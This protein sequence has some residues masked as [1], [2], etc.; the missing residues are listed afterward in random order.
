ME[1]LKSRVAATS[2][3]GSGPASSP[4]GAQSRPQ[5]PQAGAG[6][7]PA[8][9]SG[10]AP[11][12]AAAAAR[13]APASA[14]AAAPPVQHT[15][16][17]QGIPLHLGEPGSALQ[18]MAVLTHASPRQMEEYAAGGGAAATPGTPAGLLASDARFLVSL[19]RMADTPRSR[20]AA[21]MQMSAGAMPAPALL[22]WAAQEVVGQAQALL[23][24]RLVAG[25]DAAASLPAEPWYAAALQLSQAA[26]ASR[27]QPP[28]PAPTTELELLKAFALAADST[29]SYVS[30]EQLWQLPQL[31]ELLAAAAGRSAKLA[32]TLDVAGFAMAATSEA[33]G[34]QQWLLPQLR[35][36]AAQARAKAVAALAPQ[37]AATGDAPLNADDALAAA[38][39]GGAADASEWLAATSLLRRAEAELGC[40]PSTWSSGVAGAS[41]GALA[42]PV[43]HLL[44]LPLQPP[45]LAGMKDLQVTAEEVVGWIKAAAASPGTMPAALQSRLAAARQQLAAAGRALA[46]LPSTSAAATGEAAATAAWLR[47]VG[48]PL[49]S[50][51]LAGGYGSL[52]QLRS[53]PAELREALLLRLLEAAPGAPPATAAGSSASSGAS[54]RAVGGG[55]RALAAAAYSDAEAAWLAAKAGAGGAADAVRLL[56]EEAV[57]ADLDLTRERFVPPAPQLAAPPA[58]PSAEELAAAVR[59]LPAAARLLH[60]SVYAL[61]PAGSETAAGMASSEA[62]AAQAKVLEALAAAG[63]G[64]AAAAAAAAGRG[65]LSAWLADSRRGL[66]SLPLPLLSLLLRFLRVQVTVTPEAAESQRNKLLALMSLVAEQQQRA[67]AAAAATAVGGAG[68]EVPREVAALALS[69]AFTAQALSEGTAAGSGVPAALAVVLGPDGTSDFSSWLEALVRTSD[70][71]DRDLSTAEL[72]AQT[73]LAADVERYLQMTHDPR[74]QLLATTSPSSTSSPA[75]ASV[76]TSSF[77]NPA[78][79]AQ[80]DPGRWLEGARPELDAYLQAMGYRAL[81]DAEWAVYRDAALAEWEAGRP[82]REEQLAAVGQSGFHNPRADEAYLQQLLERSIPEDAPLGPQSRRYLD[83]LI[84]NPTWTFAQRLQAVQRLIQLNDHFAAQPP[85]TSEGSP[86]AAYFAVGGPDPVPKLGPLG[87]AGGAGAALEGGSGKGGKKGAAKAGATAGA[88][89]GMTKAA[90]QIPDGF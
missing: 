89:G 58:L 8:S 85:P 6:A 68:E 31:S 61:Q 37:L 29:S 72:A 21:I 39:A 1:Q 43:L 75:S 57:S 32:A 66:L 47:A 54:T 17:F 5:V 74:L 15:A 4:S 64:A 24:E 86:F 67:A 45:Q 11:A 23:K 55:A 65:E 62:A 76:P 35:S 71:A 63:E 16:S 50:G 70:Q 27:S 88:S 87:V 59:A 33:A 34:T 28:Q 79:R 84:R 13:P 42:V 82:A 81:G 44:G 19:Q 78:L 14:P 7:Q 26:L 10:R 25:G 38:A 77:S 2:V 22:V 69:G 53:M 80:A 46:A 20:A 52:R 9:T 41:T 51:L 90:L 60:D 83:T 30:W 36:A 40:A 18:S 12:A 49:A 48:G 56:E 3:G 73:Q